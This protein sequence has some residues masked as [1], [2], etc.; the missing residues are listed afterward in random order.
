MG[1]VHRNVPHAIASVPCL[2]STGSIEMVNFSTGVP[3]L[4]DRH[5]H[6]AQVLGSAVFRSPLPGL[7]VHDEVHAPA[8]G[9]VHSVYVP[10]GS[11][12]PASVI[13]AEVVNWVAALAPV[14]QTPVVADHV[15]QQHAPARQRP[16]V[17]HREGRGADGGARR[18]AHAE[19]LS[20]RCLVP[21]PRT[22]PDRLDVGRFV[23]RCTATL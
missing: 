6:R 14:R 21:R 18:V 16:S 8:C 23:V 20:G 3:T 17:V 22:I 5:R 11:G 1:A 12:N 2:A 19:L 7:L 10:A 9:T 13:G 15:A 4:S